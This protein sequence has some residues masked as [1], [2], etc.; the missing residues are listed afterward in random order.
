MT[1]LE[2]IV[3][4]DKE[5][6]EADVDMDLLD[7]TIVDDD[8]HLTKDS[9]NH[10]KTKDW[11]I[12][13]T[14]PFGWSYKGEGSAALIKAPNGKLYPSRRLAFADMLNSGKYCAKD[15]IMMKRTLI[16]QGW[17]SDERI[18]RGWMFNTI[19]F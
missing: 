4:V 14:V 18:P 17:Q 11:V 7:E 1:V 5:D 2:E 12:D 9:K 8:D 15:V 19:S 16:H 13:S 10:R 3:N 6:I